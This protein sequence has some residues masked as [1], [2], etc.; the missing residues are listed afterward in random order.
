MPIEIRELVIRVT[1]QDGGRTAA[2]QLPLP[3]LAGDEWQRLQGELI[4]TCVR[5]VLAELDRQR[6]R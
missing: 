5:Q 6:E 2:D 4:N 3:A 1:V